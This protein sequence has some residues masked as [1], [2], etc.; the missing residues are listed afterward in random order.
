[1]STP[2]FA[3]DGRQGNVDRGR[4]DADNAVAAAQRD[5]RQP[6]AELADGPTPP[7]P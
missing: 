7:A 6:A 5:D 2:N 3:S 1:M 4:I